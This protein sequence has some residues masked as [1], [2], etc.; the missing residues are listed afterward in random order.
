VVE[1]FVPD[2]TKPTEPAREVAPVNPAKP[3]TEAE[4]EQYRAWSR[5]GSFHGS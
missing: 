1:R 2:T 4:R 5:S 3:G